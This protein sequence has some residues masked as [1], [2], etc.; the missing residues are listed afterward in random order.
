MKCKSFSHEASHPLLQVNIV[1]FDAELAVT[2]PNAQEIASEIEDH[3]RFGLSNASMNLTVKS[4]AKCADCGNKGPPESTASVFTVHSQQFI[5]LIA[6]LMTAHIQS[7]TRP[8][9]SR[10]QPRSH[11]STSPR[12]GDVIDGDC[13]ATANQKLVLLENQLVNMQN[14][15]VGMQ[16]RLA[17][18]EDRLRR[19]CNNTGKSSL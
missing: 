19:V 8:K 6:E 4:P 17:L 3:L 11:T 18:M 1:L 13:G 16:D 14:Q 5:V 7:L 9:Q 10:R 2:I 15:L 12:R